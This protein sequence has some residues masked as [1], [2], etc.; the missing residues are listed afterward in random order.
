MRMGWC[1]AKKLI[2]KK[3]AIKQGAMQQLLTSKSACQEMAVGVNLF[4]K[5]KKARIGWQGLTTAE[6]LTEGYSY[7]ITGTILL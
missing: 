3:K 1:V 7:L 5:S 2:E 4:E 6:Y